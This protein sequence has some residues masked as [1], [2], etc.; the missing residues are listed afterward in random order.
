MSALRP[1]TVRG[2]KTILTRAGVP[3]AGLELTPYLTESVVPGRE[4]TIHGVRITAPL[5]ARRAAENV[6][7]DAGLAC[8]GYPEHSTWTRP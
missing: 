6:L 4:G 5:K 8:V 7:F 3:Y 2:V 1:L